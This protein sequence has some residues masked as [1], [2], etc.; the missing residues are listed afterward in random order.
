MTSLT[1]ALV[2]FGDERMGRMLEIELCRL[3]IPARAL[4][5]PP[6]S[7]Q[8]LRLLV[9]DGDS[10]P[11]SDG[12]ALAAVCGCPLL[13][14]GKSVAPDG[15]IP[16]LRRPFALPEWES[17]I[18][19]MMRPP[20]TPASCSALRVGNGTVSVSGTTV[21]LTDAEWRVFS[22]LYDRRGEVIP[23]EELATLLDGGGN[24]VEVYVCH[25]R[26]KL[27]RPLGRRLITTLRGVGYRMEQL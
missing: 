4:D 5:A 25:L 14:I 21:P 24:S 1:E 9:W 7:P 8:S 16:Y 6:K 12:E 26:R 3:G 22:L 18:R 15:H 27:E 10:F 11:T 13:V 19:E 17:V 2:I 23:R 20:S